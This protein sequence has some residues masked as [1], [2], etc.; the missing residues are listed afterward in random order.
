MS[1]YVLWSDVMYFI[2]LIACALP[3]WF[4]WRIVCVM[5]VVLLFCCVYYVGFVDFFVSF[6]NWFGDCLCLRWCLLV[7]LG[8]L[9]FDL[10]FWYVCYFAGGFV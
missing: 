5:L 7:V 9:G 3:G 2:V 8:L 1:L 4:V 6:L 10:V